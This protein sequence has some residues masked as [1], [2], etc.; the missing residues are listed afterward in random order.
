MSLF[1]LP[2]QSHTMPLTD[3]SKNYTPDW[4]ELSLEAHNV[5]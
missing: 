3:H 4:L 1:S 5:Q 2:A